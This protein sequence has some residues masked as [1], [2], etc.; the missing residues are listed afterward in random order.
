MHYSV[1]TPEADYATA[2]GA[3]TTATAEM[4]NGEHKETP[5]LDE[6]FEDEINFIS[7]RSSL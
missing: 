1:R 7:D 2:R 6:S 5:D 3:D 4:V